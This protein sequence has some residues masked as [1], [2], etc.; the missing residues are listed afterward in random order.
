MFTYSRRDFLKTGS[1]RP[2]PGC[3]RPRLPVDHQRTSKEPIK[4]GILHSLSGTMPSRSVAP[5]VVLMAVD[6][7]NAKGGVM[8]RPIQPVVVDPA[9]NWTCSRRRPSSSCSRTRSPSSSVLDVGQRKSCCRSS[10]TT[11]GC[12]LSRAVRRRG[13]QQ[14]RLLHGRHAEPAADP[15]RRI[16]DVKEGGAYKKFY[17]LGTDYVSRAPPTR[18][19]AHSCSPGRAGREHRGGVHAV[20]SSGLPDDRRQDK[21]FSSGG[22][23]CVLSTINGDSNVPFYKE[24]SNQG[25]RSETRDHGV[26]RGR[27]RAARHGHLGAGRH[28][29]AWNYFQSIENANNKKFVN[30]F[31]EY[32]QKKGL[33]AVPSA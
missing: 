8:G 4:I 1:P 21:R 2:A 20:Q 24:F 7:I 6:E 25:L 32:A 22:G 19:S 5:H 3:R 9:S 10:R 33:P 15:G 18:S 29:A 30:A 27:G 13:V 31:K 28:L 16:S 14:E 26:Q 23:A 11:T 12:F 17:L